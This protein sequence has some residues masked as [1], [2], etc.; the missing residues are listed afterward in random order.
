M[1]AGNSGPRSPD[2]LVRLIE[3]AD[4][5]RAEGSVGKLRAEVRA[6]VRDLSSSGRRA[7]IGRLALAAAAFAARVDPHERQRLLDELAAVGEFARK[8]GAS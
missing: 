8:R 3:L 2:P 4:A 7:L 5:S 1:A 6:Q